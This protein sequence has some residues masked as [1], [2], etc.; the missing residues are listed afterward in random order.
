TRHVMRTDNAS[1]AGLTV[2]VYYKNNSQSGVI[3]GDGS[4]DECAVAMGKADADGAFEFPSIT[5]GSLHVQSFDQTTLQRG[6]AMTQL[7]A[8]GTASLTVILEGG[9]GSVTGVVFDPKLNPVAGARVG[10]DLSLTKTAV[11]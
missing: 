2:V 5:A 10:G 6:D 11:V 3:C 4:S 1:A 7:A 8:N 9:L